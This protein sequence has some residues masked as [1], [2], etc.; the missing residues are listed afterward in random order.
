MQRSIAASHMICRNAG[1]AE[2]VHVGS[3]LLLN[4]GGP[5]CCVFTRVFDSFGREFERV[6]VCRWCAQSK[7]SAQTIEERTLRF[8]SKNPPGAECIVLLRM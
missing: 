3:G 7:S 4:A 6:S 2:C 5:L 1:N 8:I